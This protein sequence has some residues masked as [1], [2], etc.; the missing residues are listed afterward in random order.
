MPLASAPA[1][2]E[3]TVV[4]A[5]RA[6]DEAVFAR[7]VDDHT[8]VLLGV[9]RC[10]VPGAAEDV[11]RETWRAVV[12]GLDGF[13]GRPSLKAWIVRSCLDAASAR[14]PP[15][16]AAAGPQPQLDASRFHP[17][18]HRRQP[19]RWA[20]PPA[21]WPAADAADLRQP[22][23]RAIAGLPP[24]ERA[25]TA[26]RDVAGL[27]LEEVGSALGLSAAEQRAA[28]HRARTKARAALERHFAGLTPA[29]RPVDL[30][31]RAG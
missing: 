29:A 24:L 31:A 12:H 18:D 23:T 7:L 20:I 19:G 4:A 28:L 11:V 8:G 10:C 17:P 6:G 13:D 22:V 27:P 1:G 16:R 9:A 3:R 25:V 5:L 15:Q 30:G 14:R 2:D 26:L 21:A